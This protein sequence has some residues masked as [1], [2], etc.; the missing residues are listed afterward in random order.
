MKSSFFVDFCLE[1]ADKGDYN[2]M[3]DFALLPE[4]RFH[5]DKTQ[6][7]YKNYNKQQRQ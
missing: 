4:Y 2:T 1:A 3:V 6:T 5:L 7:V